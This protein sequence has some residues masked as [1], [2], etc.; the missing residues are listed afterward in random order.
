[1]IIKTIIRH[2]NCASVWEIA[3]AA[4]LSFHLPDTLD[5][6]C[7]S[8]QRK[9]QAIIVPAVKPVKSPTIGTPKKGNHSSSDTLGN[10]HLFVN[11]E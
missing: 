9:N 5:W 11:P 6:S 1:M 4:P 7:L 8:N 10:E 3:T 2:R